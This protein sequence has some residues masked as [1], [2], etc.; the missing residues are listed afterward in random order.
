MAG[1]K[2]ASSDDPEQQ[3]RL[4]LALTGFNFKHRIVVARSLQAFSDT[5]AAFLLERGLIQE[6]K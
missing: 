2:K 4:Y 3:T 1:K 5:E 6:V